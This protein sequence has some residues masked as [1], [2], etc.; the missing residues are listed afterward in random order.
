MDSQNT[1]TEF[2][3]E[4]Q[5][6][7][8]RRF[9]NVK[10]AIYPLPND[11]TE[12]DRLNLQHLMV[13]YMWQSNFSAPIE[14]IL[15]KPGVKILD[16]GYPLVEFVGL[17]ISPLQSTQ[18][19]PKNFTFIK[20]NVLEGIPF[21]D[22]YFDFVFQRFLLGGYKKEKWPSAINELVR[23]L[24]PGGFLE[25]CEPSRMVDLD[26]ASRRLYD[27]EMEI[28]EQQGSDIYIYQKL[29]NYLQSQGQLENIKNDQRLY[30]HGIKYNNDFQL[31]KMAIRNTISTFN[32]FKPTLLNKFQISSEEFDEL[33]KTSE[34]ELFEFD[35]YLYFGR[36]YASKVIENNIETT[37]K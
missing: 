19:K 28:I 15:S 34:K 2:Q 10:S 33:I 22:N 24:K 21:E 25:L 1:Q 13:R 35:T 30:P 11:D 17:D 14:H 29:E 36:F 7:D 16:V 23:V 6:V 4:F 27:G 37:L 3:A 8:G 31:I 9:H 5:Y 12:M 32:I 18:I 20:A 26:P